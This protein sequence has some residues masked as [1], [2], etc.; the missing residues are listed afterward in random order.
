M[1]GALKELQVPPH[2][3]EEGA[4]DF[5][6]LEIRVINQCFLPKTKHQ[7]APGHLQ[8]SAAISCL[9]PN[10]SER[11][12]P[13][14]DVR[15]SWAQATAVPEQNSSSVSTLNPLSLQQAKDYAGWYKI[16]FFKN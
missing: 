3:K 6:T 4:L 10:S 14:P 15:R 12:I 2:P 8:P 11:A 9:V 13:G 5:I 1:L 7:Q 16:L